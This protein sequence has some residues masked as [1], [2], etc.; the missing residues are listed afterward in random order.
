MRPFFANSS[1]QPHNTYASDGQSHNGFKWEK[2]SKGYTW[3]LPPVDELTV[4]QKKPAK[5]S[6]RMSEKS[7]FKWEQMKGALGEERIGQLKEAA[8]KEAASTEVVSTVKCSTEVLPTEIR[9]EVLSTKIC[10]RNTQA[11]EEEVAKMANGFVELEKMACDGKKTKKTRYGRK[12]TDEVGKFL[13]PA[14]C[15]RPL[16]AAL[17]RMMKEVGEKFTYHES[18]RKHAGLYVSDAKLQPVQSFHQ[19]TSFSTSTTKDM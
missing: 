6:G 8:S 16:K 14:G 2:K 4:G 9:T 1:R 19:R 12:W 10:Q 17:P 7:S 3:G 11:E 13:S 15:A 5:E 18:M